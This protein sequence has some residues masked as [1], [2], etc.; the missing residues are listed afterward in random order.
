MALHLPEAIEA[1]LGDGSTFAMTPVARQ[2]A[3]SPSVGLHKVHVTQEAELLQRAF[4][5]I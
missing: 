3:S 1:G 4:E 5:G 2:E